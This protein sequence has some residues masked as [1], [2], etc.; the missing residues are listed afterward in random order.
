MQFQLFVPSGIMLFRCLPVERMAC[1][2][3]H[4][5]VGV[6]THFGPSAA[7]QCCFLDVV[8]AVGGAYTFVYR[9]MYIPAFKNE[10][11]HGVVYRPVLQTTVATAVFHVPTMQCI[12]HPLQAK[13]YTVL[14]ES[15]NQI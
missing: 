13:Y 15:G 7:D 14:R 2:S 3:A 10:F 6:S 4:D 12:A 9:N 11:E 8:A 1:K 5:T